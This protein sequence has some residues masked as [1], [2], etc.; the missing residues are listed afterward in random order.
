MACQCVPVLGLYMYR[1]Y[2]YLSSYMWSTPVPMSK[3]SSPH[4]L[5]SVQDVDA[6]LQ[7]IAPEGAASSSS[8][9]HANVHCAATSSSTAIGAVGAPRKRPDLFVVMPGLGGMFRTYEKTNSVVMHCAHHD[10]CR[11]TRSFNKSDAAGRAGQGRPI[12]VLRAWNLYCPE[13]IDAWTHV[14]M[15]APTL[16]QRQSARAELWKMPQVELVALFERERERERESSVTESRWSPRASREKHHTPLSF[17]SCRMDPQ[18]T[19][20]LIASPFL[21]MCIVRRGARE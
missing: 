18:S 12:G 5:P 3:G 13:G 16:A 1:T 8:S 6:V 4:A 2:I 10:N 9:S 15:F 21:T 17:G 19:S 14:H 7:M 20:L 11:L